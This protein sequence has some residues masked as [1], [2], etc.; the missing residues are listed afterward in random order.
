MC[1]VCVCGSDKM[2]WLPPRSSSATGF[3]AGHIGQHVHTF[4]RLKLLQGLQPAIGQGANR[5]GSSGTGRSTS[6][7]GSRNI[8]CKSGYLSRSGQSFSHGGLKQSKTPRHE[9]HWQS[10]GVGGMIH[11]I[12]CFVSEIYNTV[13]RLIIRGRGDACMCCVC[14]A[15]LY[16]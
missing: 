5:I 2:F 4:P 3:C 10:E 7:I 9:K 13:T 1:S 8:S 16:D 11:A 12:S 15:P 6:G 14:V